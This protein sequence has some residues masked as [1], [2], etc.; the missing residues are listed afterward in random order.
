MN[1]IAVAA[2][3]AMFATPAIAQT[4]ASG[5]TTPPSPAGYQ[6]APQPPVPPGVTPVYV[7]APPPDVAFPPPAPLASY[8]PCKKGQF[9]G[10][11]ERNSPR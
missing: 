3:L 6:P 1:T 11:M 4:A 5:D 7:Q 9:D 8:P 10:C 2:A